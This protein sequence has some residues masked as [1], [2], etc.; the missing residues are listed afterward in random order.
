MNSF[1]I[2][3]KYIFRMSFQNFMNFKTKS[4]SNQKHVIEFQQLMNI[5]KKNLR[6]SQKQQKRFKNSHTKIKKYVEK[7][8]V[9]FNDK[10]I[11]IKRNK[12]FE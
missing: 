6:H 11:R 12:K 1:E 9:N 10:N 8:Y 4:N 7:N 2:M 5:F 3:Q